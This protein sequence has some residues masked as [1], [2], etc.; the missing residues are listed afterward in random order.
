MHILADWAGAAGL[1]AQC[2]GAPG[3]RRQL[4]ETPGST[5]DEIQ[6]APPIGAETPTVTQE[7]TARLTAEQ[8]KRNE[9]RKAQTKADQR[10]LGIQ[11]LYDSRLPQGRSWERLADELQDSAAALLQD[12]AFAT[13]LYCALGLRPHLHE[14]GDAPRD[15]FKHRRKMVSHDG[16]LYDRELRLG[17]SNYACV[18]AWACLLQAAGA[19]RLRAPPRPCSAPLLFDP[20][21]APIARPWVDGAPVIMLLL[22]R[23]PRPALALCGSARH[24]GDI[25]EAALGICVPCNKAR[26]PVRDGFG[27]SRNFVEPD[28]R[29]LHGRIEATDHAPDVFC[30]ACGR[31]PLDPRKGNGGAWVDHHL[32]KTKPGRPRRGA[33]GPAL[34]SAAIPAQRADNDRAD[35]TTVCSEAKKILTVVAG[36]RRIRRLGY[37]I[38]PEL[39]RRMSRAAEAKVRPSTKQAAKETAK[40]KKARVEV[41]HAGVRWLATADQLNREYRVSDNAAIMEIYWSERRPLVQVCSSRRKPEELHLLFIQRV[42]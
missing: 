41:G 28:F 14:P 12:P 37:H 17:L 10:A 30:D 36:W 3:T 20:A 38:P 40:E 18:A 9:D 6:Q 16:Y 22:A 27:K 24:I 15:L 25:L 5:Y 42:G 7:E 34:A 21:G 35:P 33:Q 23:A 19:A 4:D 32:L 8:R 2:T 26:L 29:R 39:D 11:T 31:G 1:W 13:A